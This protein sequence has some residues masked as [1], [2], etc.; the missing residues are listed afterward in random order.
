MFENGEPDRPIVLG[1]LRQ[2]EGWPLD[3]RP[4]S[5]EV[6]ADGERLVVGGEA[7]ARA[8]LRQREHHADQGR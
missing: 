8:A 4:G 2:D 6:Q 7:A 3:E 5:V 1:R